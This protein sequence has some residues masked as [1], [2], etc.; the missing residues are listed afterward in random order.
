[1]G[2]AER[3]ALILFAERLR[4]HSAY[5]DPIEWYAITN[6]QAS[7]AQDYFRETGWPLALRLA[8]EL[9][10]E[11]IDIAP[12]ATAKA[13]AQHS[14]AMGAFSLLAKF[15]RWDP[16]QII[17]W[18]SLRETAIEMAMAAEHTVDEHARG[19][20]AGADVQLARIR[21]VLGDLT[22]VWSG[23]DEERR[24]A[25]AYFDQALANANLPQRIAFGVRASRGTT[26]AA[27]DEPKEDELQRA[28]EDLHAATEAKGSDAAYASR[29]LWCYL[30][31]RLLRKHAGWE[32]ALPW[33]QRA[34]SL[35]WQ[36]FQA[37]TNEQQVIFQSEQFVPVFEGLASLYASLGWADD[38]LALIE[39][40]RCS[41]VR[42]YSMNA[43]GRDRFF[44]A[45]E[46]K[47]RESLRP[48][49]WKDAGM[50]P[51]TG[52]PSEEYINDITGELDIGTD[53]LTV[54]TADKGVPTGLL[55][56][57]VDQGTVTT[58]LCTED[59]AE[60]RRK[61]NG[62]KMAKKI[63]PRWKIEH[64]QWKITPEQI[65]ILE[66]KRHIE[67]GPF[68]ERLIAKLCRMGS[69]LLL[70]P[71]VE[72]LRTSGISRLL[73][74]LP[75]SM[76]GLPVE[77]FTD[78]SEQPLLPGLGI[79][80]GYLPSIRL[81]ADLVKHKRTAR[82]HKMKAGV[83]SQSVLF[84]GYGGDDLDT[85]RAE[86]DGIVD[87]YRGH[88]TYVPG[89]ES[90]KQ[91][92]LTA[93]QGEHDIIHIQAHGTFSGGLDSALHFVPDLEDDRRRITAF[94]L[95]NEVQFAR[96][97][98]IVL[99]ACSSAITTGWR[100]GTYHGLTGSLLRA[101]ASAV[102]GSRWPVSDDGAARFMTRLYR[103]LRDPGILPEKA[104]H[105]AAQQMRADGAARE[106][107]AGF[108][109]FGAP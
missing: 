80:V 19:G 108:G 64:K 14:F 71:L 3:Y 39:I 72:Q 69:E 40:T 70:I 84:I 34:A 22:G 27:L 81:G 65:S 17:G 10:A 43:A 62:K 45:Q 12:D 103:T 87:A 83:A 67:A 57:V 109:Y 55:T 2:H 16:T 88:L 9:F 36:Q 32:Q 26:L 52:R 79:S 91:R 48:V 98:I 33:L 58:L 5:N 8:L 63:E 75:G 92:V 68:R 49:S 77:A 6:A 24:G 94:D 21:W 76:S 95:L 53:V 29:W 85:N 37:V 46:K 15:P 74:S 82:G 56:L 23:D 100:T 97:P 13:L 4:D 59:A 60:A 96:A 104:L 51:L 18:P 47:A 78:A 54:L 31:S 89:T 90:T 73:V 50:P 41:S 11:M 101:G 86:Y 1:M 25:V 61:R 7:L 105:E 35:A 66:G 93:L 38:A 28:V 42:L 102:I 106:V 30:L 20:I 99:S 44:E 107:W